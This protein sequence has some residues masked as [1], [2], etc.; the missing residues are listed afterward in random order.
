[1]VPIQSD[2]FGF[3]QWP[4]AA[5]R[6]MQSIQHQINQASYTLNTNSD[7][8]AISRLYLLPEDCNFYHNT[9]PDY[10]DTYKAATGTLLNPLA[11]YTSTIPGDG[12]YKPCT[13]GCNISGNSI[14]PSA[15]GT[16]TITATMY[17]PLITPFTN[18][19]SHDS[20]ALYA[21]TGLAN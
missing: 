4:L 5:R 12:V 21:I 3:K 16:V 13:V 9:M 8:D 6:Y 19:S 18:I 10:I 20:R 17:E 14:A 2:N 11:S 15:S 7:L 1:M